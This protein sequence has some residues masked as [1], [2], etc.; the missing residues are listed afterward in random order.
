[1]KKWILLSLILILGLGFGSCKKKE[2]PLVEN[3]FYFDYKK[4]SASKIGGCVAGGM[5]NYTWDVNLVNI[6]PTGSVEITPNYYTE[7]CEDCCGVQV[8][9]NPV[10][11]TFI[12]VSGRV[13]HEGPLVGF[14]VEVRDINDLTDGE[15]VQLKG[16]YLCGD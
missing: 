9:N 13:W 4:Y 14:D 10:T 3:G 15:N 8:T 7:A 5:V 6:P 1:M 2:V 11:I 16:S 12:A